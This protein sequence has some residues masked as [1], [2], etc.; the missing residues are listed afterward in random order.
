MREISKDL[1]A[2]LTLLSFDFLEIKDSIACAIASNPADDLIL[3]D[4]LITNSENQE[5]NL[6]LIHLPLQ[7]ILFYQYKLLNLM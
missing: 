2:K 1:L 6:A 7:N 3:F 4:P 5:K